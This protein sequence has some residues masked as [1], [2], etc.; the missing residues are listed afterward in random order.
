MAG[1]VVGACES[2]HVVVAL[3]ERLDGGVVTATT[4]FG[5]PL[6]APGTTV[7]MSQFGQRAIIVSV[8]QRPHWATICIVDATWWRCD[9][10]EVLRCPTDGACGR[11]PTGAC[12]WKLCVASCFPSHSSFD[13]LLAVQE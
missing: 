1:P 2:D 7:G 12:M 5:A 4:A 6:A 10:A 11:L 13:V 3:G 9:A 8:P